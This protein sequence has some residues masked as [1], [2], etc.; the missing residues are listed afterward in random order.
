[1]APPRPAAPADPM[2]TSDLFGLMAAALAAAGPADPATKPE[3]G[4]V[5]FQS[6]DITA[7]VPERYRLAPHSFPYTL[8]PKYDLP[9]AGVEI[10]ALRFPSAVTSAYPDNNT[11]H[12]EYFRPKTG[13]RLP[14]VVVLDIL[15]GKQVVSRGK[16][17]WLAQ[18]GIPSVVVV[19]PLYGP[20][21]PAG[22]PRFLSPDVNKSL[23]NV[24]QAV[25]D[26]RRA[27][28]WLA[29]RPE[30]DP[31][32]LGVVGTS[33][34]SFV[35]G[36]VAASEPNV[37]SACLLLSGG[38]L[39]DAFYDHPRAAPVTGVLRLLGISK[40]KLKATLAPADPL[41]YAD[42]LRGKRLLLIGAS[43]DDVVPP[44]ALARLW[45]ATGRPKILWFDATH[46]GAALHAFPAL[47][48]VITHLKE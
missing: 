31:G 7:G 5:R 23:D 16:A 30:V 45:E 26:C 34:G 24:R 36:L 38:G 20:R 2:P 9:Q 10:L 8:E 15:D 43:R 39:V 17:L 42:R 6:D 25:L 41:T 3:T 32:R 48:A 40:D 13:T 33:L 18:N 47:D 44:A 29:T 11:V 27:L 4:E 1:M 21:R 28:A 22:A 19:L 46:V 35:A 12:A 14:A 37:R